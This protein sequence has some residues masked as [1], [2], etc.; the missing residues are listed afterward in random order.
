MKR[1]SP[2]LQWLGLLAGTL[3][4]LAL[5]R[6]TWEGVRSYPWSWGPPLSYW[7]RFLQG[8]LATVELAI[9]SLL[10]SLF[11]GGLL[12]LVRLAAWGPLRWLVGL[13][14]RLVRGTPL[15]V[16]TL[17]M[18]YLV[19]QAFGIS[20]RLFAGVIIL[21]SFSAAYLAEILRGGLESIGHSQWEAAQ[22][23]GLTPA[24]TLRYVVLPQALAR[25]LPALA[26]QLLLLIK[27]SSIL[28]VIAV[29][30]LTKTAQEVAALT[31]STLESDLLMALGY[32]LLTLPLDAV[33]AFW[34]S[35]FRYEA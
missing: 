23:V 27:D 7:H 5:A 10:A 34:E 14:I 13:Y 16:F 4:F 17:V 18:Y 11:F 6:L 25:I 32:W 22:A 28:S 19:A 29:N 8:W 1:F 21:S 20:Q 24:Q 12:T 35:R 9:V 30:E 15:L 3:L 26:G 2:G 33:I 31:Y